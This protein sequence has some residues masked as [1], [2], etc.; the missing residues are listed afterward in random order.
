MSQPQRTWDRAGQ[1]VLGIYDTCHIYSDVAQPHCF[2]VL[3]CISAVQGLKKLRLLEVV[4]PRVLTLN[5]PRDA[6]ES[7]MKEH[8]VAVLGKIRGH[9]KVLKMI[10]IGSSYSRVEIRDVVTQ[11]I[12]VP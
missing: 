5:Y 12:T 2:R 7:Q 1:S 3:E 11:I 10:S 8:A 4:L 6:W 9:A